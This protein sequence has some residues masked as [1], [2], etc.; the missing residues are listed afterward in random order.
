M[1]ASKKKKDR[2]PYKKPKIKSEDLIAFGALCNGSDLDGR[3]ASSFVPDFC[4][5]AKLLS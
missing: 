2:K 3:K 4:D 1:K 5:G